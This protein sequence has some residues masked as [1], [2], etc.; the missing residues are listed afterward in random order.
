MTMS[1]YMIDMEGKL[2]DQSYLKRSDRLIFFT[3]GLYWF[4]INQPSNSINRMTR[5]GH[6]LFWEVVYDRTSPIRQN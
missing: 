6:D 3:N 1:R 2:H 5:R 4:I